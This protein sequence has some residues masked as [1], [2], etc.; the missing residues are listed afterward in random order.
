MKPVLVSALM[1]VI[2]FNCEGRPANF[3]ININCLIHI[4]QISFSMTK[5]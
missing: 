5:F 1:M 2:V 3:G 4:H